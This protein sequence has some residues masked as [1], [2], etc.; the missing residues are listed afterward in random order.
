M[1]KKT[2]AYTEKEIRY[3]LEELHLKEKISVTKI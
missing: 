3:F 1:R 2:Q